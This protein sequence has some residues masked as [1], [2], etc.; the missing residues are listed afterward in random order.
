MVGVRNKNKKGTLHVTKVCIC[1]TCDVILCFFTFVSF[2]FWKTSNDFMQ[3]FLKD[4]FSVSFSSTIVYSE[5]SFSPRE[6]S[7]HKILYVLPF[8]C[9]LC[10][11]V[12]T[13]LNFLKRNVKRNIEFCGCKGKTCIAL[14]YYA[15]FRPKMFETYRVVGDVDGWYRMVPTLGYQYS[16]KCWARVE[17]K[18]ILKFIQSLTIF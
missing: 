16:L 11:Y 17:K 12:C 1:R 18:F 10:M 4:T 3:Q 8:L 14:F 6:S 15:W 2:Y 13:Q 7:Y 9:V 5:L